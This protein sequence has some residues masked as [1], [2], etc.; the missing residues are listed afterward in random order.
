MEEELKRTNELV[1]KLSKENIS[2]RRELAILLEINYSQSM[3]IHELK[4]YKWM[5]EDLNK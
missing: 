3:L 5:Y 4:E 2:L 1:E